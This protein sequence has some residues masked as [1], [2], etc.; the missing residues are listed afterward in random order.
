MAEI[1]IVRH[2]NTFDPGETPRRIGRRTDLSLSQSGWAQAAALGNLFKNR[3][4]GF[5]K[6]FSSP[7]KRTMETAKAIVELGRTPIEIA[8]TPALLEVD[9]GPDENKPEDAVRA[10][11]G[12]HAL[13]AWNEHATP[14][15]GWLIDPVELIAVWR[16]IFAEVFSLG[17]D[18]VALAVTSNGVARFA[19]DAATLTPPNAPR[20][21]R[22][23]AFGRVNIGAGTSEIREWDVRP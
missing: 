9:Y 14:P 5:S 20:K 19:L 15:P 11:I 10:R 3:N 4:V 17:P 12:E 22:T 8:P 23:G 16:K 2:G 1:Y 18:A 13:T 6:V 7:L 21:L